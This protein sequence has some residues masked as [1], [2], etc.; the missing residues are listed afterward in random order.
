MS[1]ELP[2][3]L[4]SGIPFLFDRILTLF[5]A[6]KSC[7]YLCNKRSDSHDYKHA[8]CS[9]CVGCVPYKSKNLN[10]TWPDVKNISIVCE[11]DNFLHWTSLSQQSDGRGTWLSGSRGAAS[12]KCLLFICHLSCWSFVFCLQF[13]CLLSTCSF[14]PS[15]LV[16]W[17]QNHL[18]NNY[19]LQ[20]RWPLTSNL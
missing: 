11:L 13:I 8:D 16:F 7:L 4:R 1:H 6:L 3:K 15:N 2:R 20:R 12:V 5:V 17:V 14:I 9:V 19:E 10:I 18:K